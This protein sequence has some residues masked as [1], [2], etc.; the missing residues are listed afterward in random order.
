MGLY[1]T[2][3]Q[4][5]AYAAAS[6]ST[7]Y[8]SCD[9]TRPGQ[10]FQQNGQKESCPGISA[11]NYSALSSPGG[12]CCRWEVGQ[13]AVTVWQKHN[14]TL[15]HRLEWLQVCLQMKCKEFVPLPRHGRFIFSALSMQIYSVS[16]FILPWFAYGDVNVA[17][18]C[19][20][21]AGVFL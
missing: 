7:N 14:G 20:R 8:R 1:C 6:P 21:I 18:L 11:P 13:D 15:W 4:M 17:L 5:H 2:H 19:A 9:L 3:T 16:V 10:W 12:Q